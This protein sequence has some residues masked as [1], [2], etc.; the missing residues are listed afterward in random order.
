M[1][2]R[3][4]LSC[5]R[6]RLATN[7]F[8]FKLYYLVRFQVQVPRAKYHRCGHPLSSAVVP[9]SA[10]ALS[11]WRRTIYSHHSTLA[12]REVIL[13]L[14]GSLWDARHYHYSIFFQKSRGGVIF[15]RYTDLG[16]TIGRARTGSRRIQGENIIYDFPTKPTAN[17]RRTHARAHTHI[18]CLHQ[19]NRNLTSI[20]SPH[21]PHP[22]HWPT[23]PHA[24]LQLL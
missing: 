6:V 20:I 1:H 4:P 24:L 18:Y 15:L 21:S 12:D 14:Q 10:G 8:F 22:A 16:P 11:T 23:Q 5:I 3:N 17:S 13:P 7:R 2:Y 19:M 9:L